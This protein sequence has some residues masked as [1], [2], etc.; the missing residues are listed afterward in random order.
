[1]QRAVG[2]DQF[3]QRLA[4]FAACG[5]CACRRRRCN[6]VIGAGRRRLFRS[7]N[8]RPVQFA[9]G[10]QRSPDF[11]G[12]E[13]D[14]IDHCAAG[15]QIEFADFGADDM[16]VDQRRGSLVGDHQI[17]QAGIAGQDYLRL[18]VGADEAKVQIA[19]QLGAFDADRQR[20]RRKVDIAGQV[21]L[22]KIDCQRG[23]L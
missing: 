23:F 13:L 5:L 2:D 20:N 7:A 8:T 22:G 19:A 4:G 9:L 11:R 21:E 17:A 3:A 15:Q 12:I 14:L 18:V 10:I 16:G 6:R 1:M